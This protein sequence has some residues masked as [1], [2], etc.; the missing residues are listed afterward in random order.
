LKSKNKTSIFF[1]IF[2]VF[3][4]FYL[5]SLD[6]SLKFLLLDRLSGI[7]PELLLDYLEKTN[8]SDLLINFSFLIML[9]ISKKYWIKYININNF[10]KLYNREFVPNKNSY[11]YLIYVTYA[12]VF[13][14]MLS[15]NYGVHTFVSDYYSGV[16]RLYLNLSQIN[17]KPYELTSFHFIH[18]VLPVPS[19][20]FIINLQI[21]TAILCVAGIYFKYSKIIS[22]IIFINCMYFSGFV[23]M[24]NAELEA[25][26]IMLFALFTIVF[27]NLRN[28]NQ[29]KVGLTGF[30]WFIGFYYV[31][32]GLN[33]LID[34]GP[35]FIW[36]LNLDE[37]RYVA[38]LNSV[39]LSSRYAHPIFA[40]ILIPPFISD[41]FGLMTVLTE[42][43]FI[44]LFLNNKY[45]VFPLFSAIMLHTSVFLMAGINFTGNSFFLIYLI[46]YILNGN[47]KKFNNF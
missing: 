1:I 47:K 37:Y 42:L 23:L 9:Y 19:Y 16:P 22:L 6:E 18:R 34:I 29:W 5:S 36:N 25:T 4:I 10:I 46:Y 40:D 38:A 33:K 43:G 7:L 30:N 31:S 39:A 21:F 44:L 8:V 45:S 11:D 28:P 32:S 14:R 27:T 17:F 2:I 20:D 15:R 24:T 3:T 12:Y 26:E 13:W 35:S 41:F